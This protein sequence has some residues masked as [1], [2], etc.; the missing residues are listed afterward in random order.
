MTQRVAVC[1]PSL[2]L[3]EEGYVR[4]FEA[5]A[6]YLLDAT[7]RIRG[8]LSDHR[9]R[10]EYDWVVQIPECE[11]LRASAQ[12]L[13]GEPTV[14][15]A[16]LQG[17]SSDILGVCTS[18]GFTKTMRQTLGHLPGH[19]EH[20]ALAIEMARVSLQAYPVPK[21]DHK[22]FEASVAAIPPGPHRLAR[23]VWERDR[24]DWPWLRNSCH[25]YR[26][27]SASSFD[28]HT[29][30]GFDLDSVSPEP[31]QERFFWRRKRMKISA[32]QNPLRFQ[33]QNDMTDSYQEMRVA[34]D[35]EADG[36]MNNATS[37]GVRLPFQGL[38][39]AP[40]RRTVGLNGLTLNKE[41]SRLIAD[42]VGGSTGCSHLFDLATD[43][44][45]LF[46]WRD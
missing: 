42:Q 6:D 12:H 31:G 16:Q 9:C 14:L 29:A 32:H 34:F 18:Q 23:M 35:L 13:L 36:T 8:T 41:F 27:E 38:C 39:E 46:T 17:S 15:S 22:R 3:P 11:I 1:E 37:R 43:C 10:L 24:A 4:T 7:V 44:L 33:C 45:R 25:T 19:Q 30:V 28:E 5:Q 20:L 40:Q 26:D 21:G 2:A